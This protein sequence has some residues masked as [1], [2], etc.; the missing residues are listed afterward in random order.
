MVGER[1]DYL[2]NVVFAMVTEKLVCKGCEANLA[3]V[4]DR[5]VDSNTLDSF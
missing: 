5:N 1:R 3:Y 2:S 4:M